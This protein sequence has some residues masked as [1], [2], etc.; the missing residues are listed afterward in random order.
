M[1]SSWDH[2]IAS[3]KELAGLAEALA[4]ALDRGDVI[5]L[6][7]PLGAGKTAF[8][9]ALIRTLAAPEPIEEVPSP[10]FTLVQTY[11]L[12]RFR[13]AHFDLYR[14]DDA[15]ALIELGFE[16]ALADGVTLIEWPERAGKMLP[17]ERLEVQI[18]FGA[19]DGERRVRLVGYGGWAARLDRLRALAGFI[20]GASWGGAQRRHLHGDASHRAY[21]R[22]SRPGGSAILM[23]APA[24]PD[25]PP[26]RDGKPYSAIAHLAEH[27]SAFIAIDAVLREKGFSAPEI[28]AADLDQGFVLIEDFGE[29]TFL[30]P[31]GAPLPERFAAAVDLLIAMRAQ[32]WPAQV[33]LG[34]G[35][36]HHVPP[37]CDAALAVETELLIDWFAPA[38][39]PGPV[40]P[41]AREE[42]SALWSAAFAI[43]RDDAPALVL[44]DYHSPNLMWLAERSGIARIGLLD[45]QDA[46]FGHPAY[47]LVALLQDARVDVPERLESILLDRYVAAAR[48]EK[49][50]DP[51]RFRAAYLLLGA[52]RNSKI[53]GIFT[54]LSRRD[55]KDAYLT[56]LPRVARYLARDLDHPALADLRTWY[57]R[58][59]PQALDPGRLSGAA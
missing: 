32:S 35:R 20:A 36:I 22:L 8:A 31:A 15:S 30:S 55:G 14:L 37:Y 51:D 24:R 21:E 6:L 1:L 40:S 19:K 53:L 2:D 54:R 29:E 7:G 57:R 26:L 45:F 27:V 33:N 3:E 16:E 17:G 48:R 28:L 58:F 42:F 25:G 34:A 23:N 49:V 13:L 44:R 18:A 43:L 11:A 4:P 39:G 5:A 38:F 46:V 41:E 9:R 10:T 12:A 56:H 50:F 59:L 52:Q 47:D